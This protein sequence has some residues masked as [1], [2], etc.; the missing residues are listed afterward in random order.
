MDRK[1]NDPIKI[2]KT[3]LNN[4]PSNIIVNSVFLFGSYATGKVRK[5][6]DIDFIVISPSFKKINFIKRLELLSHVQGLSKITRSVPMDIIGYT[7]EEF[8]HID[9]E[10]V[11][12]RQAKKEGKM[13]YSL[14]K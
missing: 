11:I 7:P 5:D 4:I 9:E 12:M 10:S 1:K 14:E 6:S 3:Y 13:I 2:I 8:A